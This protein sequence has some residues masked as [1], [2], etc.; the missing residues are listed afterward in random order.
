MAEPAETPRRRLTGAVIPA[1]AAA[2]LAGMGALV[3]VGLQDRQSPAAPPQN[4]ILSGAEEVGG[5]I[6]LLDT[7]GAVVTEADFAGA[8]TVI[9]FGF[10]HCPDVCP[11]SLYAL[12]EALSAP[13][14]YDVQPVFI[15]VDPQRDTPEVMAAYVR[16]DGFPAGLTGLTGSTEQIEAAKAAFHVYAS[17]A[18]GS[19][20]S[21]D[22]YNVDHTSLAYVLDGQW[23]V[24][25]IIRTTGATPEQ[26]AQ[27]I[28]A[29]LE[30]GT[31]S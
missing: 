27:C 19:E 10:T 11:T 16:T 4:C 30:R 31:A 9:Y 26:Y 13:G 25:S 24:R 22:T 5:P 28:A 14:G 3:L 2:A 21:G 29:G 6:A 15:T 20:A 23:R 1:L 7:H 12:A 18:P 8:P 17:R